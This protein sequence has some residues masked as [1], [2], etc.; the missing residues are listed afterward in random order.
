[1][2]LVAC[3]LKR[4]ARLLSRKGITAVAGGGDAGRLEA[5]LDEAAPRARIIVSAGIAGALSPDLRV[6]TVVI[7]DAV[8]GHQATDARLCAQL[9][10]ALPGAIVGSVLGGHRIWARAEDKATMFRGTRAVAA[11][12]ESLFAARVAARHGLPLAIVRAI[13]DAADED[14]PPAALVGMAPGGGMALGA[15]LGS[16]ARAPAQ[17]PALI[18]TG[19]HA[20]TAF[21][22][23]PR[24]AD[25]LA[26]LG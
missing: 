3:G 20:E 6:G 7:G 23:L 22:A 12:M 13:S 25:A 8:I 14:L 15:V 11:D 9:A 4:E 17:L 1:M 10:G 18:R 19:R 21:R 16:L 2:I 5:M 24:I 26:R